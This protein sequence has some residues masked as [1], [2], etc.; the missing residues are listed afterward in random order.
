M[1]FISGIG[2]KIALAQVNP[3][4]PAKDQGGGNTTSTSMS[5]MMS[6]SGDMANKTTVARDSQTILLEGKI[7]PGKGLIHLY[8]STPYMMNAGHVALHIPC[9]ASSKPIVNT[10]IGQAPNFK[11][12]GPDLIKELSQPAN[13]CL[14]HIYIISVPAKK[15]YHTD[16]AIQN[17]TNQTIPFP[18]SS[19]VVIG[20]DEI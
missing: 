11:V 5:N 9:D 7:I 4:V 2:I 18:P 13:M 16:V 20:V 17:P 6:T 19:T 3:M 15:V 14:Y 1:I 10:L 8:D 12:V